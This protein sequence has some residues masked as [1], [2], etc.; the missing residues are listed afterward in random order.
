[1]RKGWELV[2]PLPRLRQEAWGVGGEKESVGE[3]RLDGPRSRRA[4]ARLGSGLRGR[5]GS[6]GRRRSALAAVATKEVRS[7]EGPMRGVLVEVA[8]LV[9]LGHGVDRRVNTYVLRGGRAR[10]VA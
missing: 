10:R 3:S 9:V 2:T 1:M 4:G 8:G 5:L 6:R 7:V